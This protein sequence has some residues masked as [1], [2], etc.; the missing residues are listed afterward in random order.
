FAEKMFANGPNYLSAAVL[1]ENLVAQ[2]ND[3][4]TYPHLAF[5]VVAIYPK[6]GTFYSDHPFAILQASWVTPAKKAAAQAFRNFLLATPQQ[7]KALSSGF[8]PA[9]TDVSISAPIDSAHGVD[10]SQPK[11]LLQVPSADLVAKIKASWDEQRRKV[12]VM[13]ILDRSGSM[14]STIGGTTK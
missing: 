2:A 11:T 3:G 4:T 14:N 12:D 1:Y 13:L 5:P 8:R 6:E 10:P 9:D 7:Q